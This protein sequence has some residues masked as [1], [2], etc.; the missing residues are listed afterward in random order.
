MISYLLYKYFNFS[1]RCQILSVLDDISSTLE[2]VIP[3]IEETIQKA[4]NGE[5]YS[6]EIYRRF[7]DKIKLLDSA[8]ETSDGD[9][10]LKVI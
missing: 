5:K 3:P 10:I 2:Y 8:L 4:F 7:S 6:F 1:I 9:I